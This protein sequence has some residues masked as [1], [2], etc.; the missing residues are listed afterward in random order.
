MIN[1]VSRSCNL[2]IINV[3]TRIITMSYIQSI[4]GEDKST[5]GCI[6][7]IVLS[8]RCNTAQFYFFACMYTFS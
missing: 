2:N 6:L 5:T 4:D 1:Y 8:V 7:L 3:G